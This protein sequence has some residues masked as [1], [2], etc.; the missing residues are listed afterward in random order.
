[1]HFVSKGS[2]PEALLRLDARPDDEEEHDMTDTVIGGDSC[3]HD[4]MLFVICTDTG[5]KTTQ[6][7]PAV[8]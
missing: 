1:M 2:V 5:P 7:P 3:F 6:R 4:R 8:R